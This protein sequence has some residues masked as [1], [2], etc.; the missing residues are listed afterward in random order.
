VC[1]S[2]CIAGGN[3]WICVTGE[4]TYLILRFGSQ[5]LVPNQ[6]AIAPF[7]HVESGTAVDE[8]VWAEV[9][10]FKSSL[11]KMYATEGMVA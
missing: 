9:E 8:E 7:K 5:A 6:V 4:H 1:Q 2:D 10:N 3:T 11:R